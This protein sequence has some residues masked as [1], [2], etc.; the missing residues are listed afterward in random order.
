MV[1]DSLKVLLLQSTCG[2]G[3]VGLNS[4]GA[5]TV[6]LAN[7]IINEEH[8]ISPHDAKLVKLATIDHICNEAGLSLEAHCLPKDGACEVLCETCLSQ[9]RVNSR[10]AAFRDD[11][12]HE[13]CLMHGPQAWREHWCP[14]DQLNLF[15]GSLCCI[16]RG[17]CERPI[18][19]E[20]DGAYIAPQKYEVTA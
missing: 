10:L 9:C 3:S 14:L 15:L 12:E 19:I 11:S 4:T 6:K 13:A 17:R 5:G 7:V 20:E 1:E 16:T 18:K 8:M 2:R